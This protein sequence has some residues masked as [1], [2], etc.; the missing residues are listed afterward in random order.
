M[1]KIDKAYIK[2]LFNGEIDMTKQNKL[3]GNEADE[4]I[5]IHKIKT[6]SDGKHNGTISDIKRD[7]DRAGYD[8]CDVFID[9]ISD[10]GSNGTIKIGFPT[11]LSVASHLGRFLSKGGFNLDREGVKFSEIR[12]FL[13]G[14]NVLFTTF[15]EHTTDGDFSRI[16]RDSLEFTD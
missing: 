7:K 16:V 14:K 13:S 4:I 3:V 1:D 8:Y 9:T 2:G 15:T 12:T 5:E 11:N 10:D 6:F